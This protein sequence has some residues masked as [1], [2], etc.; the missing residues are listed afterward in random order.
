MQIRCTLA[1]DQSSRRGAQNNLNQWPVLGNAQDTLNGRECEGYRMP[2]GVRYPPRQEAAGHEGYLWG[3]RIWSRREAR[4][5]A[6]GMSIGELEHGREGRC[7]A[8]MVSEI[9]A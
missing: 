6:V 8:R 2:A 3:F 4:S 5:T 9:V 1:L 7:P